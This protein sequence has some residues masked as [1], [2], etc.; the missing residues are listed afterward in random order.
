MHSEKG[1][2]P[3]PS[4]LFAQ[5]RQSV[6]RQK[7]SLQVEVWSDVFTFQVWSTQDNTRQHKTR[8]TTLPL[9]LIEGL[10]PGWC[11][12]AVAGIPMT[13][14]IR[15]VGACSNIVTLPYYSAHCNYTTLHYTTLHSTRPCIVT[16]RSSV[17][18]PENSLVVTTSQLLW[19]T[20]GQR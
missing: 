3:G 9:I 16:P 15:A 18:S 4:E 10:W 8:S 1:L 19:L 13:S 14:L 5:Y 12:V 17:L 11:D 2:C 20:M 7:Q 6:E